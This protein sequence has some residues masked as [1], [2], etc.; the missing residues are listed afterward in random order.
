MTI[1]FEPSSGY[2]S[3]EPVNG[4]TALETEFKISMKKFYDE[5]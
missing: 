3:I 4:G 1:N 5:D 2:I